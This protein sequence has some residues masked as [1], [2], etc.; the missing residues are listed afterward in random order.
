MISSS[1]PVKKL[2]ESEFSRGLESLDL[3]QI[4]FK[5]LE[6]D[7]KLESSESLET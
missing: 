7:I 2:E 1:L 5:S 3:D 6:R 4:L